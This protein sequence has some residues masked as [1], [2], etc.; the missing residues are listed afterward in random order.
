MDAAGALI[1]ALA[2]RLR[3]LPELAVV[4]HAVEADRVRPSAPP[5]ALT[6]AEQSSADWSTKTEIGREVVLR[7][8]A[9]DRPDR[10]DRARDLLATAERAMGEGVEVPGW[11][12]VSL[13]RLRGAAAGGGPGGVQG[14]AGASGAEARAAGPAT[15]ARALAEWRARLIAP[16]N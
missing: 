9:H 16:P 6:V 11:R 4:A 8:I 10:L 2:E 14:G 7:L 3:G 15:A 13:V 1:R 5:P 12:L